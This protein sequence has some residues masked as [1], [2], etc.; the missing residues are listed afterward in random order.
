MITSFGISIHSKAKL[1]PET[2]RRTLQA[3]KS[4]FRIS[5]LRPNSLWSWQS[6]GS[7]VVQPTA[8]ATTTPARMMER[9]WDTMQ[10]LW[11]LQKSTMSLGLISRGTPVLLT[12]TIRTNA[13]MSTMALLFP[14]VMIQ[15]IYLYPLT[16]LELTGLLFGKNSLM[17][18]NPTLTNSNANP[19]FVSS[20]LPVSLRKSAVQTVSLMTNT[21]ARSINALNLLT[22]KVSNSRPVKNSVKPMNSPSTSSEANF[23]WSN[24]DPS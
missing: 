5:K 7:T 22:E 6:L 12:S 9:A 18:I 2:K 23:F 16:V 11:R 20:P 21:S 15:P 17:L 19:V 3:L 10:H 4:W 8:H 1:K 24:K 14:A 13:K